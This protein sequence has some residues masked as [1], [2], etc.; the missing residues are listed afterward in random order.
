MF[1]KQ[2]S[3]QYFT[4]CVFFVMFFFF[5]ICL[6]E[7]WESKLCYILQRGQRRKQDTAAVRIK[8]EKLAVYRIAGG[9]KSSKTTKSSLSELEEGTIQLYTNHTPWR[10]MC[11]QLRKRVSSLRRL[12][13]HGLGAQV[14]SFTY[15]LYSSVIPLV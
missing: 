12:C 6:W 3:L 9:K 14:S 8:R 15:C 11:V 13:K 10:M 7:M 1:W 2:I 5:L 4:F